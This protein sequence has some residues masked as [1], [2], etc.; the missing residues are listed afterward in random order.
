MNTTQQPRRFV[1]DA[2][3]ENLNMV[4]Q[5][6][7]K[8]FG[9]SFVLRV[10]ECDNGGLHLQAA[11]QDSGNDYMTVHDLAC[12]LQTD[13]KTVRRMTEARA[14]RQS[15]FPVPFFKLHGKL[16]R[17]DRKRIQ[18]WLQNMANRT[19]TFKPVKAKRGRPRKAQ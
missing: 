11:E 3:Q 19:P 4:T 17:F 8:V 9:R 12:L 2:N 18:E 7:K 16:L 14:Q 1:T 6:L 13:V 10:N 15:Q 5:A